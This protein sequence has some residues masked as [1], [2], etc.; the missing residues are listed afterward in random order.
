MGRSMTRVTVRLMLGFIATGFV[1]LQAAALSA[2]EYPPNAVSGQ[3]FARVLTPE[4]TETVSQQVELTA[5]ST[6]QIILPARYETQNI[7]VQIKEA[8]TSF[9]SIPAIYK[10][11]TEQLL[12]EP[13]REVLVSIPAQ[14]ETWTE[15]IEIEPAKAVW[16]SGAGLYGR[17][18]AGT[19]TAPPVGAEVA[20]GELLCRVML[21]A[22]TRTVRHT[23]VAEPPRVERQVIPAVYRTVSRRVVATPPRVEEVH[24]PAEYTDIAVQVMTQPARVELETIP[25][26]YRTIE[27]KIVQSTGGLQWAEVLCDTNT[28]A[29]KIADIQHSLK[30]AGYSVAVD[31]AYGPQTQR[32]M[33][34]FQRANGLS[35]GYMTVETVRALNVDPYL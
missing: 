5:A 17:G 13:E 26:T 11:V 25:A 15:T 3:C 16:R 10:T 21:P 23:R 28:G 24:I 14:Y 2:A 4:I 6:R 30:A 1:A 7:R 18:M 29:S 35:V 31:G 34:R 32:A 33:E 9:R 8:S 22:K 19:G 20:T 27:R 12:V